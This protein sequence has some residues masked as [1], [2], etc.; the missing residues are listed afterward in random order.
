MS[1]DDIM[2][3]IEENGFN[4]TL[5]GGDPMAHA[6]ELL[7]LIR[8][9]KA[10]GYNVWCYTGYC[11]EALLQMEAQRQLLEYIDVL[12]D[13]P[14]ILAQR[15]ISLRFKGSRNQRLIDVKSS[16]KGRITLWQDPM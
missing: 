14:F 5:S 3:V 6:M 1:D 15:D 7:P 10:G 11:F 2:A 8:R 9:I 16:L 13:G 4:V 12:V